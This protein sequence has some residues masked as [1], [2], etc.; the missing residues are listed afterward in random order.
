MSPQTWQDSNIPVGKAELSVTMGTAGLSLSWAQMNLTIRAGPQCPNRHSKIPVSPSAQQCAYVPMGTA[1][2][3]VPISRAG[4]Q[5]PHLHSRSQC[6]MGTAGPQCP[7]FARS[8]SLGMGTKAEGMVAAEGSSRQMVAVCLWGQAQS[9]PHSL[10]SCRRPSRALSLPVGSLALR[11]RC[12]PRGSPQFL[13]PLSCRSALPARPLLPSLR[14]SSLSRRLSFPSRRLFLCCC[15]SGSL[16]ARGALGGFSSGVLSLGR[17]SRRPLLSA[18][19]A[20][21]SLGLSSFFGPRGLSSFFSSFSSSFSSFSSSSS[22]SSLGPPPSPVHGG[23]GAAAGGVLT[24]E[25]APRRT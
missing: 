3:I 20:R 25:S 6:P 14:C 7:H 2:P 4:S 8:H 17:G 24:I 16:C 10:Q 5:C 15:C 12:S 13:R 22:S 19:A 1:D 9:V 18:G 21:P 11:P 23:G